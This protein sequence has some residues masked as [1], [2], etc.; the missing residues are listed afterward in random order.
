M[1]T[2]GIILRIA[3][4]MG[5]S[6]LSQRVVIPIILNRLYPEKR[7]REIIYTSINLTLLSL[8]IIVMSLVMVRIMDVLF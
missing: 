2:T 8:L 4:A 6:A 7:V 1:S 3:F 5:I